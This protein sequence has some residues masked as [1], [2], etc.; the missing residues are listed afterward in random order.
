MADLRKDLADLSLMDV[1]S[2]TNSTDFDSFFDE[3]EQLDTC[4]RE[5]GTEDDA[6]AGAI[7]EAFQENDIARDQ[8]KE[9]DIRDVGGAE[10]LSLIHI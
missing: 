9:N 7:F 3:E 8:S 10:D 1:L 4:W 2:D 6:V 5:D